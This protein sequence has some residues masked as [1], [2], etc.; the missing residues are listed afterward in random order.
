MGI[1]VGIL[2]IGIMIIGVMNEAPYR[3]SLYKL[4]E[5]ER[6]HQ[7]MVNCNFCMAT[8]T[9]ALTE[10]NKEYYTEAKLCVDCG[11]KV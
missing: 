9:V 11:A 6:T 10:E 7:L 8:K 4:T 2:T 3:L 5:F 1:G